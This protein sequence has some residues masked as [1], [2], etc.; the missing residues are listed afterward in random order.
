MKK[1]KH[2]FVVPLSP[3]NF[4]LKVVTSYDNIGPS[5]PEDTK[6]TS[7][8]LTFAIGDDSIYVA[9]RSC[10]PPVEHIAHE[11]FHVCSIVAEIIGHDHR[12]EDEPLAYLMGFMMKEVVKG[13]DKAKS[14]GLDKPTKLV[15][16]ACVM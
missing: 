3:Y 8:A 1:P 12:K 13:L 9:F 16:N 7:D 4:K 14:K 6:N 5:L 15:D 11:L 2:S 10:E